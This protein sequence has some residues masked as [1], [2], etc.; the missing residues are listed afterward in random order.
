MFWTNSITNAVY[1]IIASFETAINS[2]FSVNLH[3][4]DST[5]PNVSPW[6]NVGRPSF[7]LEGFRANITQP[8]IGTI[9]IPVTVQ[10][11]DLSGG[12]QTGVIQLNEATRIVM[13]A[14]N[15]SNGGERTLLDTVNIITGYEVDPI[16]EEVLEDGFFRNQLNIT[17][18]LFA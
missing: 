8:F 9:V 11:T 17:A 7:A 16:G 4:P 15:C 1:T 12:M 14:V 10:V 13:T 18:E 5:D 2:N 3:R 6:V